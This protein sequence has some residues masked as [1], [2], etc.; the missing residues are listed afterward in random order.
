MSRRGTRETVAIGIYRDAIGFEARARA[1]GRSTSR[2]FPARTPLKTIKA[3]QDDERRRMRDEVR[4]AATRP[5]GSLAADVAAYRDSL[6][7]EQ[8]RRVAS[9]LSAWLVPGLET[10]QRRALTL[11][12]LRDVVRGWLEAGVAASTINHRRRALVRVYEFHDGPEPPV[13]PR[14]LGRQREPEPEVRAV[15]MAL[16]DAI[17]RAMPN[18]ADGR[19]TKTK[20]R[21]Y[22][23][24]WSGMAPATMHR[25]SPHAVDPERQE[26]TL[27]ARQKGRGAPAVTLPL[28]APEGVLA[29]RWWLGAVAWGKWPASTLNRDLKAAAARYARATGQAAPRGLRLYDLRHSFLSWLARKTN[30]PLVVQRYGQHADLATTRRYMLAAIPDMVRAALRATG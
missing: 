20:A 29:A 13:L 18:R 23:L 17:I 24:L 14:R 22:F 3:W 27:P 19:A 8:R 12:E 6:T 1:K 15:D 30:N 16:L 11:A 25:L 10:K 26:M 4:V 9:E 21:L 5:S 28:V 7:V 2:R